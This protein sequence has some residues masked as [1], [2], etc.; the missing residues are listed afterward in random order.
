MVYGEAHRRLQDRFD[1]RRLADRLASVAGDDLTPY[2]DFIEA[3]DMFFVA[4][5]D[6]DGQP[7]CSY[8][9]GDPGFVRVVDAHTIA[10]PL[11]DGNGMFLTA[12]NLVDHPR[13]GLLFI[14]F[15]DGTRLR[16]NGDA[17]IER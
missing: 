16:L 11:Y 13:V 7:Q 4:T 14:D 10:F 17:S 12:G 5:T 15:A 6:A 1:T 2:R 3:R 9:G 8:K